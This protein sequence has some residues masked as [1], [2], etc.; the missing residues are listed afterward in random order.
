MSGQ[1]GERFGTKSFNRL[2]PASPLRFAR[3]AGEGHPESFGTWMTRDRKRSQRSRH[4]PW[5]AP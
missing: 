4:A 1:K 3:L 5:G 2:A